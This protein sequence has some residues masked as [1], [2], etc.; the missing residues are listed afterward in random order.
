MA[1]FSLRN[2]QSE[3]ARRNLAR[4]TRFEVMIPVPTA[5]NEAFNSQ[6]NKLISLF[7]ESTALP[8]QIIGVRQQ[9][10]Y[11][12]VFQRPFGVEYGGEGLPMTFYLDQQMDIKAFFDAWISKIVDPKQFF[13]YYPSSYS[14]DIAL[15]QLNEQNN[16]TYSVILE[17]AF[18][19]SVTLVELS[20]SNQNQVSRLNVNFAFRKWRA[21]HRS[22][23]RMRYPAV[24]QPTSGVT[25]FRVNNPTVTETQIPSD[26]GGVPTQSIGDL[27][28]PF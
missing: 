5:L 26:T 9:R 7:C 6:E 19:R 17:S 27:L 16:S 21:N 10:L 8:P 22:L 14:V 28:G 23:A 15:Y 3:V 4:P 24:D 20:H 12:P 11:G 25:V 1:M 2:F 13:V 18:P